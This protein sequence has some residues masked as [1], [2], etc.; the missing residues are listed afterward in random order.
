MLTSLCTRYYEF[1]LCQGVLG[2]LSMGLAYQPAIAVVGHYFRHKRPVA[3]GIAA[4]GSS[5]G[6]I[7]LPI[8]L[9]RMLNHTTLGFGWSQRIVG[10]VVLVLAIVAV[11]TIRPGVAPRS[12]SHLL[13]QAFE[14]PEYT[15]QIIG[16]FLIVWG[17][18]IP[19]FY[20]PTYAEAHGMSIN[21]SW[22]L[23]SIMNTGSMFGRL[24]S[25]YVAVAVGPFSLLSACCTIYGVLALCWLRATSNA[26]LIVLG[27]LFGFF[28]GGII[29]LML[30]TISHVAP[31]PNEIGTYMGMA[32]GIFSIAGLTGPPITGVLISHDH[33]FT[34]A[35]IWSGVTCLAG[36]GFICCAWLAILR[37]GKTKS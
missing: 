17:V 5:L 30:S 24:I 2:G 12:G 28:S 13:P 21:M 15:F 6:G 19:F 37:A 26:A 34:Q 32:S 16:L 29:G 9:N 27:V 18:F 25:G 36:S 4:S 33:S 23:V 22:Y 20:L 11:I 35:I 3:I 7:L 10:F 14:K 31:R 8:M 1:M